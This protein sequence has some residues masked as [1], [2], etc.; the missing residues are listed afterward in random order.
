MDLLSY[1]YSISH[2]YSTTAGDDVTLHALANTRLHPKVMITVPCCGDTMVLQIFAR[3]S[4]ESVD[5]ETCLQF[6]LQ[7]G[8]RL[9][10][11]CYRGCYIGKMIGS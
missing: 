7:R 11:S 8:I 9:V 10:V 5:T 4:Q 3:C 1:R 2:C 6:A